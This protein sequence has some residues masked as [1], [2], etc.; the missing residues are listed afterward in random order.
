M[1]R[2][3]HED[4]ST[5]VTEMT[6]LNGRFRFIMQEDGNVVLYTESDVMMSDEPIWSS[7]TDKRTDGPFQL[8]LQA[9]GNLV[10]YNEAGDAFWSSEI[11]EEQRTG[12]Y[13]LIMQDDGNVVLY[14]SE[15][16]S[17]W[18][19]DTVQPPKDA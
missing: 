8:L 6:S 12:P 11:A 14:N 5:E 7:G 17:I 19:T 18:M 4:V 10:A 13:I 1:A 2:L 9:D 16:A 3:G 15:G